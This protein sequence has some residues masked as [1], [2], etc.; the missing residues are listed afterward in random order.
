MTA[1][2]V[3]VD[4]G[5]GTAG[6]TSGYQK[7]QL[8]AGGAAV[9]VDT[10]GT[11]N[12]GVTVLPRQIAGPMIPD[13]PAEEDAAPAEAPPTHPLAERMAQDALFLALTEKGLSELRQGQHQP[14]EEVKRRGDL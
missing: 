4:I 3:S 6:L 13:V 8:T 9:V 1:R 7:T 2:S 14:L 5:D 11:L 12:V 10:A